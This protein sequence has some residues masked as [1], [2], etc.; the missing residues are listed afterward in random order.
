MLLLK[1]RHVKMWAEAGWSFFLDRAIAKT[2][3]H[4]LKAT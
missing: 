2:A 1:L 3:W 4:L